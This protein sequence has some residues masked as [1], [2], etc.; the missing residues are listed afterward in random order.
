[1]AQ[2]PSQ[3]LQIDKRLLYQGSAT[4]HLRLVGIGRA[5]IERLIENPL[6]QGAALPTLLHADFHKRNIYVSDNDPTTITGLI[7]WQSTSIEPSFIYANETPDFAT[8]PDHV[9]IADDDQEN[10]KGTKEAHDEKKYKDA[11]ISCQTFEVC[12]AGFV[13]KLRA[14]RFLDDVLLRLFQYCHSSWKNSAA[15]L[16]QALIELSQKWQELGLP[17]SCPYQPSGEELAEHKKQY[18]DFEAVQKLKLWLIRV[19]NTAS[20]GW[21]PTDAWEWSKTAHKEVFEMW[22]ESIRKA[23]GTGQEEMSEEKAERL[24]PFD[25]R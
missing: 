21:V 8:H 12:M 13:P 22:M 17:G 14:A 3:D 18:E 11:L 20:D 6:L 23:K 5:V 4:E 2:I 1:M 9:L 24:W 25:E 16:R 15:A 7:D 19:L 10:L